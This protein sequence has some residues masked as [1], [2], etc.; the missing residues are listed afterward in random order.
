MPEGELK[1]ERPGIV[2]YKTLSHIRSKEHISHV[3]LVYLAF[4]QHTG[5]QLNYP[6]EFFEDF[7]VLLMV[8]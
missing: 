4:V 8:L 1:G 2:W 6:E 7:D 3:F 5:I